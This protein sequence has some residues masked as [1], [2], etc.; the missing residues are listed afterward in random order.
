MNNGFKAAIPS[1][2]N[3][4]NERISKLSQLLQIPETFSLAAGSGW[5]ELDQTLGLWEITEYDSIHM[6]GIYNTASPALVFLPIHQR[7]LN[8]SQ[9]K[10]FF[11]TYPSPV[12]T[13]SGSVFTSE[14]E[15]RSL[16]VWSA[17]HHDSPSIRKQKK[18]ECHH[19]SNQSRSGAKGVPTHPKSA[20]C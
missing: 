18:R 19:K 7:K 10:Y 20:S 5:S 15:N 16:Q 3:P 4:C 13:L 17:H 2:E 14:A 11:P 9:D 8:F 12:S 1:W 6:S